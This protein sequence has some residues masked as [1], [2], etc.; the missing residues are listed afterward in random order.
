MILFFLLFYTSL[1]DVGDSVSRS[2]N[3][4]LARLERVDECA[5]AHRWEDFNEEA[6]GIVSSL[7]ADSPLA[8]EQLVQRLV[9]ESSTDTVENL[10]LA[11]APLPSTSA[12]ALTVELF[13]YI[14]MTVGWDGSCQLHSFEP[15]NAAH[16]G[17]AETLKMTLIVV[18]TW[19]PAQV[20]EL[21]SYLQG[22]GGLQIAA[23]LFCRCF[24]SQ[25]GSKLPEEVADCLLQ[26]P[27][28]GNRAVNE[29]LS[30]LRR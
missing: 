7:D 23:L 20:E 13:S 27:P 2:W 26:L 15:E 4:L 9:A 12:V 18:N 29:L 6:E 1:N 8:A 10:L 5:A 14:S 24:L 30:E 3:D 16:T 11:V 28:S 19:A 25:P 22:D 17:L 21:R